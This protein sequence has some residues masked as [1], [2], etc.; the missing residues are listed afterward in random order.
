MKQTSSPVSD[1]LCVLNDQT[2]TQVTDQCSSWI[3]SGSCMDWE[4]QMLGLTRPFFKWCQYGPGGGLP[5]MG[6][7]FAC[8]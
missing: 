4:G 1:P 2:D 6:K 7:A 3:D 8:M 5:E